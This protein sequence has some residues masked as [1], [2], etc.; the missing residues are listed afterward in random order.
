[1]TRRLAMATL[2]LGLAATA[3]RAQVG[4]DRSSLPTR[5]SLER[6]GLERHWMGVVPIGIGHERLIRLS[7]AEDLLFAQ[8]NGG[9]LHVYEAESGR[10]LWGASLGTETAYAFPAAVNSD[11]V[12]ITNF[13][14]LYCLDRRTGRPIWQ[15][16]LPKLP[17]SP[18]AADEEKVL[19]GLSDGMVQCY[20]IR[21]HTK[22]QPPGLSPGSVLWSWKTNKEVSARPVAANKVAAFASQDRRVY[23]VVIRSDTIRPVELLYRFLTGGPITASMGTLG[24]RT[25]LVASEDGDLYAVDLFTGA[26]QWAFSSGAPILYEPLV[27]QG[28]IFVLNKDGVLFS[29][30]P[31][32]GSSKWSVRTAFGAQFLAIGGNKIYARS[33]DGNLVV[34]DRTTGKILADGRETQERAGL[35]LR[36]FTVNLTNRLNDRIY[37]GTPSGLVVCIREAGR[38]QPSL[39]RGAEEL[40][41]GQL[42]DQDSVPTP[43]ASPPADITPTEPPAEPAAPTEAPAAPAPAPSDDPFAAPPAP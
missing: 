22:D 20:A 4:F 37:L 39:L 18:V 14:V 27:A 42:P 19:V 36:D 28:D 2:V 43:P 16:R 40:P 31:E 3:S 10:Y 24:A 30:N 32:T 35:N 17:T 21:D 8:T 7:L 9:K 1:M 5:T 26:T 6:L 34:G 29:L 41:F 23:V 38:L 12:L 13:N 33:A 25:L 11:R 15:K